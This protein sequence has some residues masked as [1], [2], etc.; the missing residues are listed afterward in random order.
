MEP[1]TRIS[2]YKITVNNKLNTIH[3]IKLYL[4][5][6]SHSPVIYGHLV[7]TLKPY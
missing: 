1:I 4:V 3:S 5:I 2:T 7:E 6:N